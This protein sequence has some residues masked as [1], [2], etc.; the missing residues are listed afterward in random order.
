MIISLRDLVSK[1]NVKITGVIHVGAHHGQEYDEYKN[2]GAARVIWIEPCKLALK[3]LNGKFENNKDVTIFPVACGE[4]VEE[5]MMNVSPQNDGMSNSLLEPEKHLQLHPDIQFPYNEKISV[6]RLDNLE[7]D[8]KSYNT[9]M[10]D[11]QGFEDR[12]LR[13]G[14]DTLKHIDYVYTEVNTDE[15]YKG[16]ARIETLDAIL[17]DFERV[18]TKMAGG[19]WGDA[20]YVRRKPAAWIGDPIEFF[21]EA[22]TTDPV[23]SFDVQLFNAIINAFVQKTKDDDIFI[24][25]NGSVRIAM[26]NQVI[27]GMSYQ[28]LL[29]AIATGDNIDVARTTFELH[30][31][32]KRSGEQIGGIV[33]GL[34]TKNSLFEKSKTIEIARSSDGKTASSSL[35]YTINKYTKLLIINMKSGQEIRVKIYPNLAR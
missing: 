24:T 29:N 10:M 26:L 17:S 33:A 27:F 20:F 9:L 32:L 4:Y 18:E 22:P 30:D 15:V 19:I 1:Y 23:I 8:R 2:A 7:F 16:C 28:Q 6:N 34:I 31:R 35:R 25:S 12:V 11:V 14:P 5:A 3:V 21:I 13:G